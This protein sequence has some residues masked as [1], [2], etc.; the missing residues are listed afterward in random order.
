[1]H[2]CFT[3][4]IKLASVYEVMWIYCN[5]CVVNLLHV[6]ATLVAIFREV[7]YEEYITKTSKPMYKY[8]IFIN[9]KCILY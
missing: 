4:A 9:N 6:S 1:M 5:I 3:T 2:Q 7:L 8:K